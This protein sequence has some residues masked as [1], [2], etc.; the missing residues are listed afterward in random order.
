MDDE[1]EFNEAFE[2]Y[3]KQK[4][5]TMHPLRLELT[6]ED[7]VRLQNVIDG[8]IS[9]DYSTPEELDAVQ[10]IMFDF[11]V[12]EMQTHPGVLVLH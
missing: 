5:M 12:R 2:E 10:D 11:K 6:K 8:V 7:L 4:F 1:K 3:N 9:L